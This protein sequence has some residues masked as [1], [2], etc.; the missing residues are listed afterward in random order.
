MKCQRYPTVSFSNRTYQ[1]KITSCNYRFI[2]DLEDSACAKSR[3]LKVL[4]LFDPKS[5]SWILY[6]KEGKSFDS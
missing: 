5:R 3:G 4:L 6:Q 1:P 2:K